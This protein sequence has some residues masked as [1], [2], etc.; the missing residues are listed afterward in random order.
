MLWFATHEGLVSFFPWDKSPVGAKQLGY[1]TLQRTAVAVPSPQPHNS[2]FTLLLSYSFI[3]AKHLDAD[4]EL[5][6][7]RLQVKHMLMCL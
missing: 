6:F 5:T 4:Y 3:S 7:I 2:L 1:A